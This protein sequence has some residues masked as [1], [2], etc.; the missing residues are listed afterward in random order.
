VLRSAGVDAS[1]IITMMFDDIASDPA[2]PFPGRV[3]NRPT[4]DRPG[5]DVYAGVR[6]DYTGGDV[7]AG[8]LLAVLTGNAS[9][10][11]P[12]KPVLS[13]SKDD[14]LF[15]YFSDHGANGLVRGKRARAA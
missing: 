1:R 10:V 14:T 13:S 4:D 6:I 11:P 12:G 7:N 8:N 5:R 9:G 2:N 3:F 15:F